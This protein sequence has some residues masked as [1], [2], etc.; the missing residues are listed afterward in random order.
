ML[1]SVLDLAVQLCPSARGL[2]A[3]GALAARDPSSGL[4]IAANGVRQQ[5]TELSGT[6]SGCWTVL[7]AWSVIAPDGTND[8]ALWVRRGRRRS[9]VCPL[10]VKPLGDA[11][12]PKREE[13]VKLLSCPIKQNKVLHLEGKNVTTY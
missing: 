13:A 4:T 10:V 11:A 6:S 5:G 2:R 3:N 9:A 1:T 7:S 12:S 8:Q